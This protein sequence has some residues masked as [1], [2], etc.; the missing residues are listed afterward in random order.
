MNTS[1]SRFPS[2]CDGTRCAWQ[3]Y[4]D[5][6][7]TLEEKVMRA[8]ARGGGGGG[9]GGGEEE[10]TPS[11]S[12]GPGAFSGSFFN[13]GERAAQSQKAKM[14]AKLNTPHKRYEKKVQY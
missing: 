8:S 7:Q 13:F 2:R 10:N 6:R 12:P 11:P 14:L 9:G 4:F 5:V 3:N 1:S